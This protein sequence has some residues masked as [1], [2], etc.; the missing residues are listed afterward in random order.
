M[1]GNVWL[2][3]DRR[4]RIKAIAAWEQPTA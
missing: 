1:A 2:R 3:Y 4:R